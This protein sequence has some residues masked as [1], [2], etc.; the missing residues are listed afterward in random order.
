MLLQ[1]TD[2]ARGGGLIADLDRLGPVFAVL[3]TAGLILLIDLVLPRERVKWL[4]ALAVAGLGASAI[5]LLQLILR[6]RW[7]SYFSDSMALDDFSVF[8]SFLFLGVCAA[9]LIAS[10]DY[11]ERFGKHQAEFLAL[12]LIATA[13]MMLLA[14][15]RDLV[16]IF[17]ALELTAIAQFILAGFLRDDRGSEAA[18]KYLLVGAVSSAVILYGMAFLYGISGTTRL[19]TTDGAP[20][21][22]DAI[23][24]SDGG[25]RSALLVAM[26]FLAAGFGYKMATVPFQ[27]WTPDVYQGA[28]T[29]VVAFLSVG[30]KAAAFAVVLRIFFEGFAASD[31]LIDDWKM[32]FAV[33]AAVSMTVGNVMAVRQT[34]VRRMLGYSSIAQAGNFLVGIAAISATSDGDP[35]G[36]SGVVF[37]LATYAFTNLGAF[38]AI[39]AISNRTGSDE[40]DDYGGL[41]RRA[42]VPAAVLTF[43][44]LSLTG[45]PPTAGFWAKLYV[46]N[47]AVQA[48]LVWL[49]IIAVL[50]TAISAFYYLGVA[51]QMYVGESK[52]DE[53]IRPSLTMQGVLL[54]AAAGVFA[55]FV[56]PYPLIE[57]AQRA[58]QGFA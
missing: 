10:V 13:G 33:L 1:A 56:Y 40:I 17:V 22:A 8:F 2:I 6:D 41:G 44:L 25:T 46:F 51:R 58:V 57:A 28:P 50:N 15:S 26:V 20:S 34:N 23:T 32:L 14:G 37:F 31:V 54:V 16:A 53:E 35:I 4:V 55:F 12:T 42:P 9:V 48:D 24:V 5:W 29:P 21:I 43:C 30:S 52:S 19:I 39:M 47:A 45:L 36:A 49:V 3:V 38:F 18:I 7:A 11:L 27:M